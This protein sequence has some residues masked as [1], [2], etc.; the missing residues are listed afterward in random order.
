MRMGLFI[1]YV[2]LRS[3]RVTIVKV[4][5]QDLKADNILVDPSGI[6][7]ISDFGI[8]KRTDDI[9]INGE[10]TSM[11]GSEIGRAHV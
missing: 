9:N 7:K 1:G 10:H 5:L 4:L 11:Q 2:F 3:C 6:C 8:S